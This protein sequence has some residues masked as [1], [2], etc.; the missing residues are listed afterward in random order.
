MNAELEKLLQGDGRI[1]RG[2]RADAPW[3]VLA[4]GYPEL[5]RVLPGGGWPAGALIEMGVAAWGIGELRLLLPV[6]RRLHEMHRW[7][8]WI[9]PPF[10]PYAPALCRHGL[11][12]QRMLRVEAG[13]V[14]SDVWWAME[15]FLRHPA[16]GLVMAWPKRLE[17]TALRRLQLAAEDGGT[18]GVLFHRQQGANTPAALKLALQA[19]GD[20]LDVNLLKVRGRFGGTTVRVILE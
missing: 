12:L 16:V 4:T 6:M 14:V 8:I 19:A 9:E 3:P 18:L 20:G 7:L 11:D 5:D 2:R 15:K 1:W 13:A 10:E 17:H